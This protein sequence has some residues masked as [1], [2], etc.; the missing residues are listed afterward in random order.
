MIKSIAPN[1]VKICCGKKG[2]PVVTKLSEDSYQVTDDDGNTIV[3]KK[4]ELKLMADAVTTLDGSEKLLL[5]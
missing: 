4:A 3:V 5:G 1:Q 2:C